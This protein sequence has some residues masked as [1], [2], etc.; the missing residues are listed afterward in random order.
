MATDRPAKRVIRTWWI[1]A[2][3]SRIKVALANGDL[4]YLTLP[5]ALGLDIQLLIDKGLLPTTEAGQ[6]D[7]TQPLVVVAFENSSLAV[8][9]LR[10]MYPG[11]K[12][13]EQNLLDLVAGEAPDSFST[14]AEHKGFARATV[15]NLDFTKP[16]PISELG[17]TA[18]VTVV[19]K[20]AAVH[21]PRKK[22]KV[23]KAAVNW[24]LC[25]TLNARILGSSDARIAEL[26]FIADQVANE[27]LLK[28]ILNTYLADDIDAIRRDPMILELPGSHLAQ[29]VLSLL[30]PLRI[31][32][33][34]VPR[35]WLVR[36]IHAARYGGGDAACMVSF[37][38][39]FEFSKKATFQPTAALQ[40]CHQKLAYAFEKIED[41]GT[42]TKGISD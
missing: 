19:T 18:L 37:I 42:L 40:E 30:I 2:V 23:N 22:A 25:L 34:V 1:E 39:D 16:W 33:A 3:E 27:P 35:G 26:D 20:F 13:R 14:S 10:A 15:V 32:H 11:L 17:A 24:T 21:E 29:R 5:G 36:T 38:F 8:A 6:I 7:T 41:D 31:I 9:D 4:P 12:V 28:E